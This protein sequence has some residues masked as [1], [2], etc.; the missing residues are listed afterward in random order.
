MTRI[1]AATLAILFAL[2]ALPALA[3]TNPF[4][5][6]V[7]P[8]SKPAFSGAAGR[9]QAAPAAAERP[10]SWWQTVMAVERD[11]RRRL[12]G[13]VRGVKRG[14]TLPAAIALMTVS[15]LYGI[16]H[17][18]GPGHGKAVISSYVLANKA[19]LRRG[20]L[21]SFLAGLLQAFSAV[22]IFT[23]L[24][25]IMN[26]ILRDSQVMDRLDMVSALLIA[27]A[28]LWFFV[29]HVRRLGARGAVADSG[30]THHGHARDETC[31]CEHSHAPDARA[32]AQRL[33]LRQSAAIVFAVGIRPCTGALM[34]LLMS[35]QL[36]V[37]WAG[38]AATFIMALGT[39]ITVSALASLAA[40]SRAAAVG[41]ADS[42]WTGRIHNAVAIGGSLL[43]M[44]IG[45]GLLWDSFGPRR[46]F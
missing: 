36:A 30:H 15:F 12:A 33:S 25:V 16:I 37:F 7:P 20:I 46:P 11:L 14:D 1:A 2:A 38:V 3:Q 10:A 27:A 21:L 35:W 44:L 43:V 39:S 32:L 22:A 13:A 24:V 4:G 29:G 18:V 41:I 5:Q 40:G 31:G 8:V 23:V 19:T 17:A 34:A 42:R 6:G 26:A 9:A 45:L 28:G